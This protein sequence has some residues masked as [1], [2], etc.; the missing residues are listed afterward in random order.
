MSTGYMIS[1]DPSIIANRHC[2]E[3]EDPLIALEQRCE[4]EEDCNCR[5]DRSISRVMELLKGLPDREKD[6]IKH[7]FLSQKRQSELAQIF[8]VTQA[9]IS[10]RLV[11]GLS[12]LKFLAN[13]PETTEEELRVKLPSV[14]QNPMDV[15]ILIGMWSTTCQSEVAKQLGLTQGRVRHRFF[16][17][18]TVL[19]KSAASDPEILK[20]SKLFGAIANKGFNMK[21]SVE[22]PQW[23]NR[24]GD[25]CV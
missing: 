5:P 21:R 3:W 18:V 12:R 19:E 4:E 8:E 1:E 25:E 17:A 11:R 15:E 24:G 14:F 10:Y 22:L 6:L 20:F 13:V 16:K 7:Y 23:K 9:A 2:L